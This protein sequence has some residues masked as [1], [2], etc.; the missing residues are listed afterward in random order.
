MPATASHARSS[1][2]NSVRIAG[3]EVASPRVDVLPEQRDLAHAVVGEARHLG[4]DVAR[5]AAL[6]APADR[7]DDAVRALRVAAHRHLHPGLEASLAVHRQIGREVLVRPELARAGRRS[8]PRRSSRRDAGSSPA[9]RRRRRT[10]TARRCARAGPPR[11][12]R[13]RRRRGR[14]A[15]ASARRR[16]RGTPRAACPASRGSC[17]C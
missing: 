17:T 10:D 6:L 12:S 16:S 3:R 4:D 1:S 2:P 9:R 8:R 5:P 15:R 7:R 14:A 11:S 13:R